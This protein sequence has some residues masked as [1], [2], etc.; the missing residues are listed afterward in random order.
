MLVEINLTED[1][2]GKRATCLVVWSSLTH[3][4]LFVTINVIRPR[5]K[6]ISAQGTW[7]PS[8]AIS[9]N[10]DRDSPYRHGPFK[11]K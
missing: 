5:E 10:E 9:G 4:S 8:M 6:E 11:F 3:C 7:R 2:R 1:E